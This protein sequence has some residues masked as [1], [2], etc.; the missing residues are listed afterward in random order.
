MTYL[1]NDILKDKKAVLFDMDGTL[2]DS[3][4][5]WRSIDI[6]YLSTIGYELPEDLQHE[7]E[8]KSFT[9]TAV[10]FKERFKIEDDLD[11]IMNRWNQMAF[12][13]YTT[14]V[15]LKPGAKEFLSRLK[16]DGIKLGIASSNSRYLIEAVLS[17]LG[18]AEYFDTIVTA[19]EAGAG[20]TAPDIYL[21]AAKKVETAPSECVV[22][23]D[24]TMGIQAGLNAGMQV[25]AVDDEYSRDT[26]DKK[27]AMA[28]YFINDY[29]DI[30]L[31]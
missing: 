12:E 15:T 13:K 14:E 10:Y 2:I 3:M 7:I 18:I 4:W 25:C 31:S 8:G 6:D 27:K 11:T 28:D 20:K 24:I 9:E 19:C 21:L 22:F 16:A 23:E 5:V 30:K 29:H 17:V 26:T 1:Y